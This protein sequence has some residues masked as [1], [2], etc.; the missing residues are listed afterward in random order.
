[1]QDKEGNDAADEGADEA[2]ELFDEGIPKLGRLYTRRAK[3]YI[4]LVVAIHHHMAQRYR[5]R[6]QLLEEKAKAADDDIP[7][8]LSKAHQWVRAGPLQHLSE[9]PTKLC[10]SSRFLHLPLTL[11]RQ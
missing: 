7:K 5:A 1:M 11:K 6:A 8:H 2:I 3:D 9:M 10:G 4:N